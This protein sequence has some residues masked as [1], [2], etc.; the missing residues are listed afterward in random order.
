MVKIR[1]ICEEFYTRD[2][3]IIPQTAFLDKIFQ[4][5]QSRLALTKLLSHGIEVK[6]VP[7]HRIENTRYIA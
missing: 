1:Y 4:G 2:W 5:D 7:V 6:E 3:P